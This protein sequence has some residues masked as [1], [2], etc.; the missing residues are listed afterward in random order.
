MVLGVVR[1][2]LLVAIA[3]IVSAPAYA[4]TET[5]YCFDFQSALYGHCRAIAIKDRARLEWATI[6]LLVG[7]PDHMQLLI[8]NPN[9]QCYRKQTIETFLQEKWRYRPIKKVDA[10]KRVATNQ[11]I[12]G[13]ACDK[14]TY[15]ISDAN[16][17]LWATKKIPATK[18]LEEAMCSFLAAPSG[19]GL[20][21]KVNMYRKGRVTRGKDGAYA[22]V[23]GDE[24]H[25]VNWLVV[26]KLA[27]VQRDY[28]DFVLPKDYKL[29]QDDFSLWWSK[30][31]TAKASD[32]DELFTADEKPPSKNASRAPYGH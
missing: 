9:N 22:F 25:K 21:V 31:G 6:K 32:I 10:L 13:I 12:S 29:A 15:K 17:E 23:K 3:G 2:L 28:S 1:L 19:C 16:F 30:D 5:A 27:K 14:Y 8:V 24:E 11:M 20:P 26:L 4:A 7:P 18:G